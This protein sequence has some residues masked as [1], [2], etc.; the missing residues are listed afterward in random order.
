MSKVIKR[1][2]VEF[3]FESTS[4]HPIHIKKWWLNNQVTEAIKNSMPYIKERLS[5]VTIEH[6]ST[7]TLP[8][9]ITISMEDALNNL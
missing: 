9:E 4:E 6:I 2:V 8:E 7:V 1:V 5:T 3:E